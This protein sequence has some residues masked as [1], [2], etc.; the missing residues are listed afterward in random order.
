MTT[1]AP[2]IPA[3][4]AYVQHGKG[5][6]TR[7]AFVKASVMRGWIIC[8][9]ERRPGE[10]SQLG[11]RGPIRLLH[12]REAAI[13]RAATCLDLDEVDRLVGLLVK[14]GMC[15]TQIREAVPV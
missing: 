9:I 4:F 15:E 7:L 3:H 10:Q 8:R 2:P 11:G 1:N 13:C 6:D 12:K 5:D 14:A